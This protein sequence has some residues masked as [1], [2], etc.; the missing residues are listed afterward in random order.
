MAMPD[1]AWR[2]FF[3]S[4]PLPLAEAQAFR[5]YL[6]DLQVPPDASIQDLTAHYEQF[7]EQWDPGPLPGTEG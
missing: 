7:C 1:D 6:A 3:Q 4:R 2:N 5:Q